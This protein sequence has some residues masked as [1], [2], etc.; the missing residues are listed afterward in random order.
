MPSKRFNPFGFLAPRGQRKTD[1]PAQASPPTTDAPATTNPPAQAS[2]EASELEQARETARTMLADEGFMRHVTPAGR[3]ALAGLL[4]PE[5]TAE[6]ITQ[7]IRAVRSIAQAVGQAM[8]QDA[9]LQSLPEPLQEWYRTPTWPASRRWLAG[10][11]VELPADAPDL[12]EVA[13]L[14]ASAA[15]NDRAATLQRHAELLRQA[16]SGGVDAAY[17]AIVGPEA[18][19]QPTQGGGAAG[20][21]SESQIALNR[22]DAERGVADPTF[23]AERL[24]LPP[25]D[26]QI[27]HIQAELRRA[28][29]GDESAASQRAADP[30]GMDSVVAWLNTSPSDAQRRY[31]EQHRELLAPASDALLQQLEQRY[32][33]HAETLLTALRPSLDAVKAQHTA[34]PD[35]L[36]EQLQTYDETMDALA[37]LGSSRRLLDDIRREGGDMPAIAHV[38]ANAK[39]GLALD[40]PTWLDEL[41]E[42]LAAI[43]E[44]RASD[45]A[46]RVTL[47]Q[48]AI[49]QA[50]TRGDVAAEAQAALLETLALTLVN[51][52]EMSADPR[53]MQETAIAALE[54][55]LTAYTL[56]RYP[57]EYAD[58]QTILGN[59]LRERAAGSRRENI[60]RAIAAYEQALRGYTPDRYSQQ[61][62]TIQNNLGVAYRNRISGDK[63]ENIER[64]IAAYEQ[65]LIVRTLERYPQDY[66][67]TQNNLGAAY[68]D[69]AA[70]E[71]SE[72][73]ER[74]IAAYEQALLVRT[75]ERFPTQHANTQN[76]LGNV[77]CDRIL[78]EKRENLE[79]AIKCYERALVVR[80][81]DRYPQDYAMTQNNLGTVYNDRI[82]GDRRENLERA[83][84]C[85]E[86]A[87]IVRTAERFPQQFANTQ[88]NLG[89]TY[90]R[91]IGVDK[92][93]S[94]ERAIECYEQALNVSPIERFPDQYADAQHD[95]GIAYSERIV[96]DRDENLNHSI[97]C[98]EQ[99]LLVRT[100]E[101][102]PLD[103]GAT[104]NS[105][106]LVAADRGDWP[107]AAAA[108][109]ATLEAQ[110]F[111]LALSG[112]IEGRDLTL[113]REGGAATR[114]AY[115]HMRAGDAVAA[116][117]TIERGRARGLAETQRLQAGD[118]QRIGDPARRARYS[119]AR[120][121]LS[122]A[123]ITLNLPIT[124]DELTEALR[125]HSISQQTLSQ[126]EEAQQQVIAAA[127]R[128]I[129]FT[130]SAA[131]QRAKA[132]FNAVVDDVR[133]AGDPADFLLAPLSLA[134]LYR[135]AACGGAG[136]A[137]CYV[138]RSKWGG[139]A[140]IVF[141]ADPASGR[142]ARVETLH[143]PGLTTEAI[144]EL[145]ERPLAPGDA[146]HPSGYGYAQEGSGFGLLLRDWPGETLRER[147]QALHVTCREA[148]VASTLD[149]AVQRAMLALGAHAEYAR[150]IDATLDALTPRE[151]NILRSCISHLF[152]RIELTR[153]LATMADIALRPLADLLSAQ[154]VHSVTLIPC[155]EVAAYPLA[156][157]EIAP[158]ITFGDRFP[159]SVAPSARSLL[160]DEAAHAHAHQRRAG[161]ATVGDPRV[162]HQPLQWGEAEALTI[163]HLAR[164]LGLPTEVRAQQ[165]ATRDWLLSRFAD[166][167]L[168][169]ASC[170]GI[171]NAREPLDSYLALAGAT[172]PTPLTLRELLNQGVEGHGLLFG[173]RLLIL[174]ACQTGILDLRGAQDEVRSMT[175]AVLEAGA[176]AAMGALWSVDDKA[177]YL[178][179]VR[180]AQ[181]WL[182]QMETLAPA[183]ALAQAQRWLRTVTNAQL[184]AWRYDHF[185]EPTV[186]ER[187]EAGCAEPERDPWRDEEPQGAAARL[188]AVRG[189]GDRLADLDDD[190]AYGTGGVE[191]GSRQ[192]RYDPQEAQS[193]IQAQAGG[194]ATDDACPYAHPY[195][196]AAFQVNG[197]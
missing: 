151:T 143:L 38:Y 185:P 33:D 63:R 23:L 80:T 130:R 28:L 111:M 22:A 192:E 138:G 72:N 145:I 141:A 135:A 158:G 108:F 178:L 65:A 55:A 32:R 101:R 133:A 36:W 197:W 9:L 125:A 90:R 116:A 78:G 98:Y 7:G 107:R 132:A 194:H 20:G 182:P 118:P 103:F 44:Q 104:Q 10:H 126:D 187:R 51:L 171:F 13:A 163:A 77:Y 79:R 88:I 167:L 123:Q 162:T 73:L 1:Q 70:G 8:E 102:R 74:A 14:R 6:Q 110:N 19:G 184:R 95:L 30:E 164:A 112:S 82:V 168:V 47:L 174:S 50:R 152:L 35:D 121:S 48:S 4:A 117:L 62:A 172:T 92:S 40:L 189:P 56:D 96:G 195:Y 148:G 196:W 94:I 136:H 29:A 61:C 11:L 114:A 67:M 26:P 149:A 153:G 139:V 134:G 113:E 64:A 137:L 25:G 156:A 18:F 109:E 66:G 24:G 105:L 85:Y 84:A 2:V 49:E 128:E 191:R 186:E 5:A 59:A 122:Q 37:E 45:L 17:Q 46:Q 89:N 140:V 41:L 12:L 165:K 52:A 83:I 43:P 154:G 119:E 144:T 99:A 150:L 166:A 170:H 142:A 179:V 160:R 15:G 31:L 127:K 57:K 115:A 175:A 146:R 180:F 188:I 157:A 53:P 69:R 16:R 161:V 97:S 34:L 3:E 183:I 124:N 71:R 39:G 81:L 21:P 177:T 60:E 68:N 106:G 120:A 87:L 193:M 159:A 129:E 181:L 54:N 76:N 176:D 93:A 190:N 58:V 173:L 169:D 131:F 27:A 75:L 100:L 147:A 42:Q 91:R 155:G 86:Q